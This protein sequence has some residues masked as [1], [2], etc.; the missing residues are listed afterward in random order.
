MQVNIKNR[1]TLN[2]V[3]AI[4]SN[5]VDVSDQGALTF[6]LTVYA[7]SGAAALLSIGLQTSNDLETWESVGSSF[8]QGAVA[9]TLASFDAKT[10]KYQRYIRVVITL[11][12]TTP[13][14]SYSLWL[15][16]FPSA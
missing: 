3:V 12:G 9:N 5:P 7:I 1:E 6:M 15:N 13:L 4:R 16:G 8:N 11:S 2:G 10:E 14:V